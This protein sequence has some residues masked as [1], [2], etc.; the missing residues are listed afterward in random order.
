MNESFIRT[1]KPED[2]AQV[3]ALVRK[4][5]GDSYPN[6]IMYR[7]EEI[8]AALRSGLMQSVIA[9]DTSGFVIGHCALTFPSPESP[10]PEAG[11]M[12][13]DPDSRGQHLSNL[14]AEH[15]RAV[16]IDNGLIGYWSECVTNHPFSQ[17]EIIDSGGV[18]TGV[19]I[20]REPSSLHMSGVNNVTDV[21]LSLMA[22]YVPT[23]VAPER[24]LYLPDRYGDIVAGL[25][26]KL[27][28]S[29]K[30]VRE[31][32][33]CESETVYEYTA[34]PDDQFAQIVVSNIGTDIGETITGLV[35]LLKAQGIAVFHLDI[36][37]GKPN[38]LHAVD[39]LESLGFFW[40]SWC[41]R[42]N[43]EK[44][45]QHVLSER[46]RVMQI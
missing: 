10:L 13:V 37:L 44:M 36:P 12:I 38:A 7:P 27:E 5:Y 1:M 2:A 35:N 24:T 41:A 19:F 29:R 17:H 16:A 22:Y 33:C 46:R 28:I 43:G 20:A 8:S 39:M 32:A 4:C 14:L 26:E 25:A 42:D 45:K 31:A 9:V 21:R 6:K 18:E 15:R 40:G 11:K 3:V 34:S 23:K 30:I